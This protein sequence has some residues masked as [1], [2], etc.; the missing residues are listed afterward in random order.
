[1]FNKKGYNCLVDSGAS[2]NVMPYVVCHKLGMEPRKT[3]A[4]IVQLN[5]SRVNVM[6]ELG[7][8]SITLSSN[9]KVHKGIDVNVMDILEYYGL[10][11]RRHWSTKLNGYFMI[12]WSHLWLPYKGKPNKIKAK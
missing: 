11:L 6:G 10:L 2:S 3:K 9:F 12:D 5:R 8:V 7:D 1:M 4:Q